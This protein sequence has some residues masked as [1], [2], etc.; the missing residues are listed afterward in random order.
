MK[1][2]FG[3]LT[4]LRGIPQIYYGD[5]IGMAGHDDP[6]DRHDFPGGFPGDKQNAFTQ[7]GRTPQ[8]QEIYAHLQSLLK[9]R[10]EHP[11]LREGLQ[12]H[13]VVAD[14]Y[15]LFTRETD[16]ERL[17][18]AFY[19][20]QAAKNLSVDLTDTSIADAKSVT[21]LFAGSVITFSGRQLTVQLAPMSVAVYRID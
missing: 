17:L 9:L 10:R 19:K 6:D 21:P 3:L 13:V 12:K 1:A 18:V 15:Y 14:D 20:G 11:A 2:A 7:A 16:G 5:E 4:T 8:Q